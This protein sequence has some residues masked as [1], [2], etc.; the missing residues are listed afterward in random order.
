[1]RQWLA[2]CLSINSLPHVQR[3]FF[4]SRVRAKGTVADTRFS[5]LWKLSE[6]RFVCGV[7]TYTLGVQVVHAPDEQ[8]G[9]SDGE[10]GP[11]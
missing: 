9:G 4:F 8:G 3:S 5:I 7:W 11:R 6:N 2:A 10:I 1:M